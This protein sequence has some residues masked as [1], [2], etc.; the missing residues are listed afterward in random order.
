MSQSRRQPQF[1]RVRAWVQPQV[2]CLQHLARLACLWCHGQ[3]EASFPLKTCYFVEEFL[4]NVEALC[5]IRHVALAISP[6]RMNSA[7]RGSSLRQ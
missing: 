6:F 3:A 7:F 4:H 5:D 1:M 2:M